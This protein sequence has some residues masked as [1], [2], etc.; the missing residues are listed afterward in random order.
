MA[1]DLEEKTITATPPE[2]LAG[3]PSVVLGQGRVH[4]IMVHP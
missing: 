4:W 2:A 3:M 1:I